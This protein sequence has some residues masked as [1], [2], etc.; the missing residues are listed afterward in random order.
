MFHVAFA[1]AFMVM[2]I[3]SRIVSFPHLSVSGKIQSLLLFW[4]AIVVDGPWSRRVDLPWAVVVTDSVDAA[5]GVALGAYPLD[6]R[7]LES[8]VGSLRILLTWLVKCLRAC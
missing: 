6:R 4:H 8:W 5:L 2:V 1:G 3:F 7:C